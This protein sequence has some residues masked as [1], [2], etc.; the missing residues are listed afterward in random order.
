MYPYT[1]VESGHFTVTDVINLSV[2]CLFG[3]YISTYIVVRGL[4]VMMCVINLSVNAAI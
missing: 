3:G 2:N 1:T 4:L